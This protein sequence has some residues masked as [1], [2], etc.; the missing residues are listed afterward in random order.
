MAR[1]TVDPL[2]VGNEPIIRRFFQHQ[3]QM[4][5]ALTERRL[6]T[7]YVV[8]KP[9]TVLERREPVVTACHTF[10]GTCGDAMS[11]PHGDMCATPSSRH[12]DPS[13]QP[14]LLGAKQPLGELTGQDRRI[15]R[16]QQSRERLGLLVDR[17]SKNRVGPAPSF[18]APRLDRRRTA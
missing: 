3:S 1:M 18:F 4:T 16:R 2:D 9:L 5:I 14:V 13:R 11:N 17:P 8:G 15:W 12:V 7:R 6:R 10:T